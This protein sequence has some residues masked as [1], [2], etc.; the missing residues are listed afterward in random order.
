MQNVQP[1]LLTSENGTS[2]A[3]CVCLVTPDGE[4]TMRPH[5]GAA[6][7]LKSA[8]QLPQGWV[9]GCR[10]LHCEGYCL[11]RPQLAV[12]AMR[13]AKDAG[14]EVHFHRHASANL[15]SPLT[16]LYTRT[17]QCHLF[18]KNFM[19]NMTSNMVCLSGAL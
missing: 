17:Q 1:L 11:Y 5:L 12:G 16:L 9:D 2:T 19:E 15:A 13:A 18:G 3:S 8:N 6:A 14:A 10:L 4:R 7:E